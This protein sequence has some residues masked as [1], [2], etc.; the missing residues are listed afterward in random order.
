MTLAISASTL[1]PSP[2]A[3]ARVTAV[4]P[5]GEVG[6]VRQVTVRF[7]RAVVAAGDPRTAAPFKLTCNGQVPAGSGYWL[8]ER[9]WAY[10]LEEAL[11]AG[12]RCTLR[13]ESTF[14]PGGAAL[15][16]ASE[17]S[18][19]TGAPAVVS[20]SPSP[21]APIEEDQHFLLQLTGPVDV[22]SVARHAWCEAEGLSE[23][24]AV[25]VVEGAPRDQV[26]RRQGRFAG[27]ARDGRG[28]RG[29]RDAAEVRAAEA[30]IAARHVLLACQRTFAPEARVRLVWGAGIAGVMMAGQ[31]ALVTRERQQ[32]QW[33]ARPRFQAEFSCERE[34]AGAPCLPLRPLV[35]R[36]NA[37]VPRELAAAARLLPIGG[38]QPGAPAPQSVPISPKLDDEDRRAA[39]LTEVRFAAPLAEH[40]RYQ[41]TLPPA[42]KDESGRALANAGSF[43]LEVA[44]GGLPPLAK[45]AGAPFG[46]VE[47]PPATRRTGEPDAAMLPLTLRHVQADLAGLATTG[48]VAIKRIAPDLTDAALLAWLAR[49]QRW[50]ERDLPAKEAGLP[51]SQWSETVTESE[52][53]ADGR[54]RTRAVKRERFVPSRELSIFVGETDVRRAELPQLKDATPRA[55]EVLGIPLRERGYH[56]V[57]I[58]SRLLG[59]ALLAKKEPMYAR[60]GVLVTNLAV[61]F[62]KGR[63]SS[64][65]WVTTLDRGRPVAGARVA[66][67]D[68]RG[69][70]L[71]GGS[72]DANGIARI[73]RGFDAEEDGDK[74]LSHD[75]LFVTARTAAN[76]GHP[77][78]LGFVFS[79]WA[80]G[81]EPWRFN[82]SVARGTAPDRRAHTAFDRTLLRR[83]ETV[84]MKHFVRDETERGLAFTAPE[85]LPDT[86]VIRHVGSGQEVTMPLAWPGG[87]AARSA[88]SQWA[89]PKTAALGLYDVT[90]KRGDQELMAGNFRVEDFRVPLVDARLAIPAAGS[91]GAGRGVLI[92]P[93]EVEL[94]A[95]VNAMAGGPMPGHALALSALVRDSEPQF[96]GHEDFNFGS[97]ERWREED[98]SGESDTS[99]GTRTVARQL[100]ARTDAQGAARLTLPNLPA[101]RGPSELLAEM[102]FADPN[103]ETQTVSRR[104]KLWPAAVVVGVRA[105]GWAMQRGAARFTAVVL[106]TEGK[107]LANR[108]VEVIGRAHQVLSTRQRIVGGFYAYD[109]QRR[110]QELG[111]LC[112]GKTDAQGRLACDARVEHTGEVELVASAR[113]DAGRTSRASTHVWVTSERD[114]GRFWFAQ[115]SDDR[116]DILPERRELEPGQVARLQVRMPFQHAT[117]LVTVERE[118]VIDARVMTINGR[119]PVIELPI[120]DAIKATKSDG[121]EAASWA[122][123][124]TIGVFVLRGRLREAPWWSIFTWGWRAPA[125]WWRAFRYEGRE[126]RAPTGTVDLA[127][128]AFKFGVAQ[129]RIGRAAH[130]LDV[131]V[132]TPQA[133]YKVREKVTATVRVAYQ[134]KPLAGA[135]VA[136]A[137]VDEG[138]L[139]LA[140]NGSWDLLGGLLQ[141]RPWGVETATAMNEVIGRRHYG[142][143]ALPPGG[144]GGRNPTR[145][146]F[147]TLLLWRGSVQLDAN[148][149]ARIEVPLN[150]SLTSFR[151][152]ALADAGADRFGHGH[153]SVRVTQDLQMLPGLA[154]LV[155]EGDRFDAGFT[156]RNGS[157][158][159]MQVRATLVGSAVGAGA[160]GAAG[161]AGGAVALNFA[162]QTVQLAAGAAAEVR[163]PVDVPAG[164]TRLDWSAGASEE[165]GGASGS[166]TGSAS[167][168]T[169]GAPARDQLKMSQ[170]VAPAVPV[171]VLQATLVPLQGTAS[172]PVAAPA[173]A[174]PGRGGVQVTLQPRLAGTAGALPGLR[175]FFEQYPFSCLEQRVSSVLALGDT[176]KWQTLRDE[177][178]GHLDADGLANY[179]PPAPGSA[180]RGSDRL[181]AYLLSATQEAG[182]NFA[183][184]DGARAAMLDGLAAFVEGRLERRFPAP[185]PDLEVRKLAALDA[186]AR[187]GRADARWWG[188]IA[189][190]PGAWPTSALLD[191]WG[192]LARSPALPDR[193]A[194]L[195]EVQRHVKSRLTEGGTTLRFSTEAE[196]DQWWWLMESADANAARLLLAAMAGNGAAPAWKDDLPRLVNGTLA[197]QKGGAWRTTTANLW[198]V[199][200]LQRFSKAFEAEGVGGRSVVEL[201]PQVRTVDWGGVTGGQGATLVLPWPGAGATGAAGVAAGTAGA[202]GSTASAAL[203]AVLGAPLAVRHEGT[204]RPWLTVQSLAAVP[205]K[206]PLFAGY[207]IARGTSAVQR[208]VPDAWSRGDVM[209]VRLE[210]DAHADMSW[211]VVS[212][213]LP[214]GAAHLGTGLGR[215][216]AIAT[217]GERRDGAAWPAYEERAHDAWRAYY[218]WLPRGRHVVEYTIRLNGAG[219][220]GLPSTRVEA[221]YAPESFG[222]LPLAAIEVRP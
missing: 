74:C 139:A 91:A 40:M 213:P 71:W 5:Q 138:L 167:S 67:N 156:V 195:A 193:D 113:D 118:G 20:L 76:G 157:P 128:P 221:M 69:Q 173:D 160:A 108:A 144:G 93:G 188:S 150:D 216:S 142:R 50:H 29:A 171:R 114:D 187:H 8:D 199:L 196:D 170:A 87:A 83:G 64:L 125:D 123:N 189:F 208:R 18:F 44:T 109:N 152:V 143:K 13:A 135:D 96:A 65:V 21:G 54:T 82:S 200:A 146:L 68:C 46:I 104:V 130:R 61:H 62:K 164:T 121:T 45:F 222:E 155:R 122:P 7:D 77:A 12:Q 30:A 9:R 177:V 81:I 119:E 94:H 197:R 48:Q 205:L 116:I 22:A 190:T 36:F 70:P 17:F 217:Q 6:V 2:A 192:A 107:P 129:L 211:V 111:T 209:R 98:E 201:G 57:E 194:R 110:T 124:V 174:L 215:D 99:D 103:G 37:P 120:P 105:P 145:E 26:L 85:H 60:T 72:T 80:R 112:S 202:A 58:G 49:V 186:L 219:R 172:V 33:T 147:D 11:P 212:D 79:R 154:P 53:M 207:R 181:T 134:G 66:V 41:L 180:A 23:R 132:T 19:S 214:A 31:P 185:R 162:P 183:L 86:L 101:L 27:I 97:S 34:R 136:F 63:S 39:T 220:F 203:P 88:L 106:D 15:E 10:D 25:R 51:P 95:Q 84:S 126:W 73:E 55:T 28:S 148:G 38:T 204:G 59:E 92:A 163:W 182:A 175:R 218:A 24:I 166:A 100:P 159:A 78:D 133:Q 42:L 115:D 184:P 137:A 191:A 153:T 3:A 161:G 32:W 16:G 165:G 149:E 43:P 176:A 168:S 141:E 169:V 14:R 127:K 158:R 52:S 35:L 4:S 140:D 89:I 151:L 102:S 178:A 198:G 206:A 117:A 1:L 90:L 179:F 56:V 131:K 210:I 47:A 75:G